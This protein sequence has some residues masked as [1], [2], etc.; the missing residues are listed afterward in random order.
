M[1]PKLENLTEKTDSVRLTSAEKFGMLSELRTYADAHPVRSPYQSVWFRQAFAVYASAFILVV[2]TGATSFAAERSLPGDALYGI[3]T[4]V[5]EGVVRTLPLPASA[6]AKVE[7]SMIDRRMGEL[8]KMIVTN[9]DTPEKVDLVLKKIDDHKEEFDVQ[10]L[11]LSDTEAGNESDQ[12]H[13]E[14]E[15]VVDAH[16]VVLE[17]ITS[18]DEEE[19]ETA[20]VITPSEPEDEAEVQPQS[21]PET[22]DDD[23]AA[24]SGAPVM[25]AMRLKMADPVP[26]QTNEASDAVELRAEIQAVDPIVEEITE[27]SRT[28]IKP[29]SRASVDAETAIF[30]EEEREGLMNRIFKRAEKQL[31]IDID[32]FIEDDG[33]QSGVNI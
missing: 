23:S 26:S 16:I 6:K 25:M 27:F 8:E 29:F 21:A 22:A 4:N 10:V 5:N 9:Q 32:A 18:E 12:I 15:T 19:N 24:D 17:E 7:I 11:A 33:A 1:K 14:L 2:A 31:N 28:E 13:S 30:V 3:K 20:D